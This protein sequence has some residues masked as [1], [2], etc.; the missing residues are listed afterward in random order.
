MGNTAMIE[1]SI[2]PRMAIALIALV[3]FFD[4]C[5]LLLNFYYPTVSMACPITG[6]GCRS[7]RD[8]VWSVLPP[9]HISSV[10]I[11]TAVPGVLGY[12][13]ICGLAMAALH[14][15]RPG[16]LLLPPTLVALSSLGMLFSLGLGGIQVFIIREVCSWCVLS[17]I[18]MFTIW[19]IALYDW[20]VWWRTTSGYAPASQTHTRAAHRIH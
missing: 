6:D 1:R 10:G 11:P 16:R 5:Y 20:R 14:T 13:L 17:A 8:S 12:A 3:G 4:A 19:L 7:V 9:A 18:L 2:Y 15:D